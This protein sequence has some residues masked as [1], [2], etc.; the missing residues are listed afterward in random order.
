[1]TCPQ[2]LAPAPSETAVRR[3]AL[4]VLMPGFDGT[5]VPAWLEQPLRDG[6]G[7]VC[8]FAV[9]TPDL[10]TTRRLTGRL[11][12]L[13]PQVCITVDEEGGDVTRLQR[14]HGS[15]LPG[16]AALGAVDDLELTR[17][18]G[19]ATGRLVRAAGIDVTLAPCVDV[20][21]NPANP[22]IG[23]RSFGPDA[24]LVGRHAVAWVRGL[25]AA[26]VAGCAKHF[27]G[28][29]D[30]SVDSHVGMPVIDLDEA[31]LASRELAPFVALAPLVDAVMPGHI[32][33]PRLGAD[34]ASTSA[35]AYD[36]IRAMGFVG[37]TIT[38]ALDMG[39]ITADP[40]ADPSSGEDERIGAAV[41]RALRAGADL[42]CLGA[43]MNGDQQAALA[44]S[45]AAIERAVEEGRLRLHRLQVSAS[46][47]RSM[48][49]L[50]H[51]RLL[52]TPA[53]D[54]ATAEDGLPELGLEVARR[55]LLT[56][57]SVLL[58]EGA[59]PVL[60][61]LGQGF[62]AAAG[63]FSSGVGDALDRALGEPVDR[64]DLD[65]VEPDDVVVA[66]SRDGSSVAATLVAELLG[67]CPHAVVV[68]VGMQQSAPDVPHLV[69]AHGAGR[70]NTRAAV[71]ALLGRRIVW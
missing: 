65:L 56:R 32:I 47:V 61:E 57:G 16:S 49:G 48:L 44:A 6:L 9:N 38:D 58:P 68:H 10:A 51:Q 11:R 25:H 18:V 46:R 1:M 43:P 31:T 4:G 59:R 53:V 22:V 64:R 71:E 12:E 7:G 27:P 52:E 67:R 5:D 20:A 17:Q 69:L 70:S 15:D 29:G 8:L 34:P 40:T 28:H 24:S 50:A 30:T 33:V 62:N 23:T 13:G 55:A 66:V 19:E 14:R 35:W 2:T 36:R 63:R 21:S 39:A 42:C 54:P 45:V 41:V 3:A 60:V 37:P 26:G